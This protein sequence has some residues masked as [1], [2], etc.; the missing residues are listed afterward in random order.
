MAEAYQKIGTSTLLSTMAYDPPVGAVVAPPLGLLQ[1]GYAVEDIPTAQHFNS[2]LQG[3][4][5]KI[6]HLLQNG[7][8]LWNATTAYVAG[9][10]V[11]HTNTGWVCVTS[12]TNS[13][14]TTANANWKQVTTGINT[15]EDVIF[16]GVLTANGGFLATQGGKPFSYES[17]PKPVQTPTNLFE[18]KINGNIQATLF[19][20]TA[21]AVPYFKQFTGSN[22]T[23]ATTSVGVANGI[24]ATRVSGRL[25]YLWLIGKD[26]GTLAGLFSA[27]NTAPTMP[28][29]YTWRR[30]LPWACATYPPIASYINGSTAVANVTSA[31]RAGAFIEHEI[32]NWG[33][34]TIVAYTCRFPSSIVTSSDDC[35]NLVSYDKNYSGSFAIE[36]LACLN[37][38]LSGQPM[39]LVP[40]EAESVTLLIAGTAVSSLVIGLETTNGSGSYLP[41]DAYQA[42]FLGALASYLVNDIPIVSRRVRL[43]SNTA[44]HLVAVRGFRCNFTNFWV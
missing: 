37:V 33:S 23:I 30:L 40:P 31:G 4:G 11:N 16:N 12:N 21:I 14:P 27:S 15:N 36:N 41:V 10:F 22:L 2:L 20:P 43:A 29:G 26:D 5:E 13:T 32:L 44:N 34:N 17:I 3:F 8:P 9:N 28:T 24:D 19:N 35:V 39:W 1:V 7:L 25:Y 6:N 18:I 38:S 42:V